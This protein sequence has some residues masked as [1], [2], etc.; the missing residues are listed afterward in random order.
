VRSGADL[1][2]GFDEASR[3]L[4]ARVFAWLDQFDAS[5]LT[6]HEGPGNHR[7]VQWEILIEPTNPAC[8]KAWI[9][10]DD[11]TRHPTGSAR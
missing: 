10:P 2:S 3:S 4:R 8:S 7:E 1:P 6:I 5:S 11:M 9:C